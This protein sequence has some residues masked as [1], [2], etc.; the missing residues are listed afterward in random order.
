MKKKTIEA[1]KRKKDTSRDTKRGTFFFE[2]KT[3]FYKK[4]IPKKNKNMQKKKNS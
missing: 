2:E 1:N 4:Y 3:H